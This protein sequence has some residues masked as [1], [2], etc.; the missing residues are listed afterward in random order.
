MSFHKFDYSSN[1][2]LN[3]IQATVCFACKFDLREADQLGSLSLSAK[4]IDFQQT[5]YGAL[6]AGWISFPKGRITYSTQFFDG[7][8]LILGLLC[9]RATAGYKL[10]SHMLGETGLLPLP[11]P[12]R[13]A[14]GSFEVLAVEERFRLLCMAQTLLEN[15]P[16]RFTDTCRDVG[17]SSSYVLSS[18]VQAPFWLADPVREYLYRRHYEPTHEEWKSAKTFLEKSGSAALPAT[19]AALLGKAPI[20]RRKFAARTRPSN[21]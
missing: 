9:S 6:E 18:R 1:K 12:L 21:R 7:L 5:I 2:H 11:L 19:V 14:A 20:T 4:E 16:K 17:I 10:F 15:W 8:H 13:T 3:E